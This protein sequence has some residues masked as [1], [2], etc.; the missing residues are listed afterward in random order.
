MGKIVANVIDVI[1]D[2]LKPN[3]APIRFETRKCY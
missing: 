3:K 2:L 1:C